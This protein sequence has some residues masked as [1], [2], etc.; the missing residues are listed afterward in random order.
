VRDA[1]ARPARGGSPPRARRRRRRRASTAPRPHALRPLL[2]AQPAAAPPTAQPPPPT[3]RRRA[4]GQRIRLLAVDLDGT[5]LDSSSRVAPSSAAALRSA[6]AAGVAVVVATGKARPAAVA[7]LAAAGL[8]GAGGVV[9]PA[10]PGIFLQG[11][12]VHGARGARLPVPGG[13][14]PPAVVRAAY[15]FARARSVPLC[16]FLG[17]TAAT[18]FAAPELDELHSRYY[19]P[20]AAVEPDVEALLAGPPVLKL[21]F[22]TDPLIVDSEL[23]PHW[24]AALAGSGAAAVQAVPSM[25]EIVPAGVNKW[26]GM[27]ALL[28]D[29][30]IPAA[31][32][33]AVGDGGNDLELLMGAGVGVAMGNAVP[34]VLAV[35][36][37][38]V[39]D[40]DSGGVAEA[41]DLILSARV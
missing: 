6:R 24:A 4:A 30:G 14:L 10:H 13:A 31:A 35:A 38:V 26:T 19:E 36:D 2:N 17:E 12:A 25:L 9:G 23:K 33:A 3:T 18:P 39:A 1:A 7:A 32:L 29:L 40:H 27:A 16:A 5:L 34:E 37:M 8:A 28:A 20:R 22:M 11:L 15:A 21:L 41:V